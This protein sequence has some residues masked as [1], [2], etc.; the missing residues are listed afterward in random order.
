MLTQIINNISNEICNE[1]TL[2]TKPGYKITDESPLHL[3]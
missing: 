3:R 1:L 2:V